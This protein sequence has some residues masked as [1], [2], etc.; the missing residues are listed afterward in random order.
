[1]LYVHTKVDGF[2]RRRVTSERTY[3]RKQEQ[4]QQE[5]SGPLG[6][7]RHAHRYAVG[8]AALE[9]TAANGREEGL[10][11]TSVSPRNRLMVG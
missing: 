11:P 7:R 4:A 1:M 2:G 8:G 3:R 9:A 5:N 10:R 6:S